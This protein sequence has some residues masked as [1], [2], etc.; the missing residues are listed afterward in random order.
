MTKFDGA[1][2]SGCRRS[3]SAGELTLNGTKRPLAPPAADPV[4]VS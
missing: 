1:L 3:T 4:K 2:R